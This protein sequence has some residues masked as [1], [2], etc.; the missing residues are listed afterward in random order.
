MKGGRS[1]PLLSQLSSTQGAVA[2]VR[3]A[4]ASTTNSAFARWIKASV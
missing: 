4:A 3:Q 1:G 2:A